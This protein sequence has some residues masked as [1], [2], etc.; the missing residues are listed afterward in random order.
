LC[1]AILAALPFA[2]FWRVA[3]GQRVFGDGDLVK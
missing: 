1:V 2:L 3:L